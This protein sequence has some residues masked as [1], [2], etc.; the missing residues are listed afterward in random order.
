MSRVFVSHRDDVAH[1]EPPASE[2]PGFGFDHLVGAPNGNTDPPLRHLHCLDDD[3]VVVDECDVDREPDADGVNPTTRPQDERA[4][5]AVLFTSAIPD[6][7]LLIR[8]SGEP[9]SAT[10][11]EARTLA[12]SVTS[13]DTEP[14]CQR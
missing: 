11:A 1:S 12:S 6:P 14:V 9:A 8:T 5:E 10:S 2:F 13:H 3:T 7:D 4:F